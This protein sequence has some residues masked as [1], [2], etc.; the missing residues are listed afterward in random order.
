VPGV[1]V[2]DVYC[3][4]LDNKDYPRKE[5]FASAVPEKTIQITVEQ[6]TSK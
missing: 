4:P 5:K 3:C 2:S 1:D 6:E